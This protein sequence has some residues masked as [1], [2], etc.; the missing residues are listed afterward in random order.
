MANERQ[1]SSHHTRRLHRSFHPFSPEKR[2]Q[3]WKNKHKRLKLCMAKGSFLLDCFKRGAGKQHL[4]NSICSD[5]RPES[6]L[7][8]CFGHG[9]NHL[10]LHLQRKHTK[11][12]DRITEIR[13]T[14][15]NALRAAIHLFYY[16]AHDIAHIAHKKK[17]HSIGEYH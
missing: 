7:N 15:S 2:R 5:R 1:P 14:T 4:R 10:D 13:Q 3:W 8:L 6:L 12:S 16:I 17:C 11:A 9:F